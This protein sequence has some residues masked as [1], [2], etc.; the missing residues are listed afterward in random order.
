ML[1][2]GLLPGDLLHLKQ[3]CKVYRLPQPCPSVLRPE[4]SPPPRLL[5]RVCH[6]K[7]GPFS[8][9]RPE[10]HGGPHCGP[11]V[12]CDQPTTQQET[13]TFQGRLD[14]GRLTGGF[15]APHWQLTARS[16]QLRTVGFPTSFYRDVLCTQDRAPPSFQVKFSSLLGETHKQH[17]FGRVLLAS[18]QQA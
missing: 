15:L 1:P 12:P 9:L 17:T 10:Q 7:H 16:S 13:H 4:V 5:R 3:Q 6:C 11:R 8:C 14:D 2:R 18:W